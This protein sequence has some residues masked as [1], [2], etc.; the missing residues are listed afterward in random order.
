M[1]LFAKLDEVIQIIEKEEETEFSKALKE[2]SGEHIKW[3]MKMIMLRYVSMEKVG[4]ES[5]E[6]ALTLLLDEARWK[7]GRDF[8]NELCELYDL[9]NYS[10]PNVQGVIDK[11]IVRRFKPE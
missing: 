5:E 10:S 1:A 6:E 8:E 7:N 2:T 11:E 4:M 9:G 3:L